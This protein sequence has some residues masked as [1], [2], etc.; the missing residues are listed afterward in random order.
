MTYKIVRNYFRY[1]TKRVIARRLT[2]QEAQAHC[3][4][5]ETSSQTCTSSR[6][7]A[8]TR[9]MGPWFDSYVEEKTR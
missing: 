7:C 2:L 5:P 8:R 4:D 9:A 6:A 3:Q 1:S